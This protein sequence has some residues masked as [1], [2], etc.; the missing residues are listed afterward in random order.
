M[1]SRRKLPSRQDLKQ[2]LLALL[3]EP[4]S[5]ITQS[6]QQTPEPTFTR[7]EWDEIIRWRIARMKEADDQFPTLDELL[8]AMRN[9]SQAV[10]RK[11]K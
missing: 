2:L 10:R 11:S 7:S 5:D 3:L 8:T 1:N 6:Q 9:A 4:T